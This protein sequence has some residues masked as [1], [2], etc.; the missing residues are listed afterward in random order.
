MLLRESGADLKTIQEQLRHAKLDTTANVYTHKSDSVSRAATDR[1][2]ALNPK[3]SQI[4][5]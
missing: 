4:A 2:E 3:L 1:L 5:P